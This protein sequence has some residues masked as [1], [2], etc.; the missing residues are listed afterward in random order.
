MKR[1]AEEWGT[2]ASLAANCRG[3]SGHTLPLKVRVQR[4]EEEPPNP[5]GNRDLGEHQA[6]TMAQSDLG[7]LSSSQPLHPWKMQP[8]LHFTQPS[9]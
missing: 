9:L 5:T 2:G 1:E 4:L 3:R 8:P 6:E 7:S